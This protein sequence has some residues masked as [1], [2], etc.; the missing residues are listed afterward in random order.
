LG[1]N[2]TH[3]VEHVTKKIDV[4]NVSKTELTDK[5]RYLEAELTDLQEDG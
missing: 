3:R 4:I 1:G 2:A 5:R